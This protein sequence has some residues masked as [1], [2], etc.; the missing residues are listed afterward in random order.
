[1]SHRGLRARL[2]NAYHVESGLLEEGDVLG[3]ILLGEKAYGLLLARSHGFRGIAK[4]GA[5]AQL[6]FDEDQT[7]SVA[8]DQVYFPVTGTVVTLD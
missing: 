1:M 6:D 7:V 4:R 8:Q 5:A 2:Q 3:Y